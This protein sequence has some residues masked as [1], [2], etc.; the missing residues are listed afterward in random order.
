MS[1]SLE[2]LLSG[3]SAAWQRAGCQGP[4]LAGKQNAVSASPAEQLDGVARALRPQV[5]NPETVGG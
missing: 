1:P 4:V 3:G 2:G 5:Q